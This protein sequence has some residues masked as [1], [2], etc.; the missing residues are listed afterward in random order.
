MQETGFIRSSPETSSRRRAVPSGFPGDT[1]PQPVVIS[2]LSDSCRGQGRS[3]VSHRRGRW[4]ADPGLG[5]PR[6]AYSEVQGGFGWWAGHALLVDQALFTG[7]SVP[8]R[9]AVL[10]CGFFPHRE[11]TVRLTDLR[12]Q[13]P[14]SL[15]SGHLVITI[16]SEAA[17]Y[18]L[19]QETVKSCTTGRGQ[20]RAGDP[21]KATRKHGCQEPPL[22]A[23]GTSPGRVTRLSCARRHF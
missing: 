21:W 11:S 4:A 5:G 12:E 3:E 8:V 20:V 1:A 19:M 2:S 18:L 17:T 10:S 13:C 7:P 14:W 9:E 16:L 23:A 6:K 15:V 22:G